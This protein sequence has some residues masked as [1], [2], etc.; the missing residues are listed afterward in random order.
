MCFRAAGS[1]YS[2]T[3]SHYDHVYHVQLLA[4]VSAQ[5]M[6]AGARALD[7]GQLGAPATVC[8]GFCRQITRYVPCNGCLSLCRTSGLLQRKSAGGKGYPLYET[9]GRDV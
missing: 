3:G 6:Y 1:V 7:G 2:C 5:L 8:N 9:L 4:P